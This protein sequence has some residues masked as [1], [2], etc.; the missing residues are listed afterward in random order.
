MSIHLGLPNKDLFIDT[1]M[2]LLNE[3]RKPFK[4][5][6]SN[7]QSSVCYLDYGAAQCVKWIG[8]YTYIHLR[9]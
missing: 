4:Q 7:L 8:N 2:D 1:R 9:F 3:G 5:L 6:G